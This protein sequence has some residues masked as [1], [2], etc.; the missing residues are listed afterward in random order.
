M[1][2]PVNGRDESDIDPQLASGHAADVV[3]RQT[4]D[5]RLGDH[6]EAEL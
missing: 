1:N 2:V 6:A 3:I 5:Q 4:F